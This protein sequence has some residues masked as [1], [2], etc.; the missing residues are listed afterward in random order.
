VDEIQF[1]SNLR[2]RALVI[3]ETASYAGQHFVPLTTAF[4]VSST[5]LA[6]QLEDLGLVI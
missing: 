1:S 6:I 2:Y 4:G 3:A 5:A